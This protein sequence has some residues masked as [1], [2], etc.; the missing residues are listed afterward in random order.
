MTG[1]VITLEDLD[2]DTSVEQLKAK[3]Q[4]KDGIPPDQQTL[5]FGK[6]Q[7]E[8]KRSL[9]D[10]DIQDQASLILLLRLRGC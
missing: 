5:L 3:I 7:L 2:P 10:Y 8:G 6:T 9:L 4:D 1:R